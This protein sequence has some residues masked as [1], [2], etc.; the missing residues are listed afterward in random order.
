MILFICYWLSLYILY[1]FISPLMQSHSSMLGSVNEL[2][3]VYLICFHQGVGGSIRGV[4]LRISIFT[5]NEPHQ[6]SRKPSLAHSKVSHA[7]P[8]FF[9]V[10]WM[11]KLI[12]AS[13]VTC[14]EVCKL[15]LNLSKIFCSSFLYPSSKT[16][17]G[18]L[19]ANNAKQTT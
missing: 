14:I 13:I 19:I 6:G 2:R 10:E 8:V 17:P 1:G 9:F 7:S 18:I 11:S 5:I 15:L 12:A 16:L 4:A 3:W